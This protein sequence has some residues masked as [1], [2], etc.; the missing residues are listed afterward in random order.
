MLYG[1]RGD[2]LEVNSDSELEEDVG[3]PYDELPSFCQNLFQKYDLLK[4]EKDLVLK[5]IKLCWWKTNFWKRRMFP[6][7]QN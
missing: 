2:P 6:Y 7:F 5:E 3:M 1:P 4:E